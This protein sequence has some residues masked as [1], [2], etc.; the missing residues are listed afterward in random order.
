MQVYFHP[1][2][3]WDNE[4]MWKRATW[5]LLNLSSKPIPLFLNISL[6]QFIF[7]F[8]L[9]PLSN[10]PWADTLALSC[11]FYFKCIWVWV[12]ARARTCMCTCMHVT[13][14]VS[15]SLPFLNSLASYVEITFCTSCPFWTIACFWCAVASLLFCSVCSCFLLPF[16]VSMFKH[17]LIINH[18]WPVFNVIRRCR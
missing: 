2:T 14:P 5:V 13:H 18:V 4:C 15:L 7:P 12:C 1:G 16:A 3:L 8:F 11:L 10:P 9:S 17:Q 6:H